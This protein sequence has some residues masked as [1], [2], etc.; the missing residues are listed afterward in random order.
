[1][2][3]AQAPAGVPSPNAHTPPTGQGGPLI[4][5]SQPAPTV[6]GRARRER[7]VHNSGSRTA[8]SILTANPNRTKAPARQELDR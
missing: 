5:F 4:P 8:E 6:P 7:T 1:M 3:A 2:N